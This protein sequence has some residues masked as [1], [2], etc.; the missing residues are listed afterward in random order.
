MPAPGPPCLE[1]ATWTFTAAPGDGSRPPSADSP[2]P[3][4]SSRRRRARDLVC[5][6]QRLLR[7]TKVAVREP[8]ATERRRYGR[9]P[10]QADP[11]ARSAALCRRTGG[12]SGRQPRPAPC[13]P[14]CAPPG[15]NTVTS[16]LDAARSRRDPY[17]A[18]S[19]RPCRPAL[20][21]TGDDQLASP[22]PRAY[23]PQ[24]HH[25]VV[26]DEISGVH[27]Q[28][29]DPDPFRPG[30]H[31]L[32]ASD[33]ARDHTD[34]PDRHVGSVGCPAHRQQHGRAHGHRSRGPHQPLGRAPREHRPLRLR[35]QQGPGAQ[36]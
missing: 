30:E 36:P 27:D 20:R 19:A 14:R 18:A 33:R 28:L 21:P 34:L 22:P 26:H 1:A 25:P 13:T 15:R 2:T 3:C 24:V 16:A 9:G 8:L 12:H 35:R 7:R 11:S 23:G 17:L 5:A 4:P 10:A 31:H 29:V 32:N 6:A